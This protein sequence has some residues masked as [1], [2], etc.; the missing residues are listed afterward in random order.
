M[1]FKLSPSEAEAAL[2]SFQSIIRYPTVSGLASS[3]GAYNDCAQY[4]LSQLQSIPCLT[5]IHILPESLPNSPVATAQWTGIHIDWPVLILNSHYD[6][7]PAAPEDWTIDPFAAIR[8][9]G[10][11]RTHEL[12]SKLTAFDPVPKSNR[13]A[14]Q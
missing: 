1:D 8:K 5:N 12:L 9:D 13:N 7:V 4:I 10:K 6:V 3:S 2:T 14:F 11:V